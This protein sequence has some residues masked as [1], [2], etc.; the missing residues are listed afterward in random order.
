MGGFSSSRLYWYP[1]AQSSDNGAPKRG[2]PWVPAVFSDCVCVVV[3]LSRS[4]L[5][6]GL[7]Q[8]RG[9]RDDPAGCGLHGESPKRL[10]VCHYGR[11]LL[12]WRRAWLLCWLVLCDSWTAVSVVP[13]ALSFSCAY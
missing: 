11:R 6:I 13:G 9:C 3:R 10:G 4:V 12:F 5:R 1:D 2:A 7:R 8:R